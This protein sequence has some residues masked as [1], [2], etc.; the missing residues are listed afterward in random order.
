LRVLARFFPPHPLPA[1]T[2]TTDRQA[3]RH[4]EQPGRQKEREKE[5]ERAQDTRELSNLVL[6]AGLPAE[7]TCEQM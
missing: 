5:R 2:Y 4:T 6:R 1:H 7:G 3:G